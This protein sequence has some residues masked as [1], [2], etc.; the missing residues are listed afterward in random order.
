MKKKVFLSGLVLLL[1]AIP[2]FASGSST[3][4]LDATVS[5]ILSIT[6]CSGFTET[7]DTTNAGAINGVCL[8]AVGIKANVQ[9]W[10]I[11]IKSDNTW[12]MVK[13]AGQPGSDS[14]YPYEFRFGDTGE[15]IV[16]STS[17]PD[18]LYTIQ[19]NAP[20]TTEGYFNIFVFYQTAEA[21]GI[22]AGSYTDTITITLSAT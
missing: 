7:L 16:N 13:A 4:N 17:E 20:L 18:G 15:T 5:Q 14:G 21:L 2:V 3:I 6:K 10:E 8:G 22:L 19:K 11:Q 9:N 1:I 12:K